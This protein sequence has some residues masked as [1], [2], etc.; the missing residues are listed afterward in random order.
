[1]E[2][3]NG[4]VLEYF[5]ESHTYIVDG[6]EV[7]SITQILKYKFGRKYEGVSKDIL[8]NAADAG[9]R[10]HNAIEDWCKN[11]TESDLPEVRNFKFLQKRYGFKVL[12]NEVPVI[13]EMDGKVVTAGRL[14]LVL[15]IDGKIGGGD[16]KRTYTLD[17]EYLAYQLNLY[18]IAYR[19]TYGV[20]WEFLKGVH[21]RNDTR[22][23]VDIPIREPQIW[24]FL[25]KWEA[26]NE[27]T[28]E[29]DTATV[30]PFKRKKVHSDAGTRQD[31]ENL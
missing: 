27:D 17:K 22:K 8:K 5:D 11:G 14:D 23:F 13:L 31:A 18:R 29:M 4:H 9:T 1:M 28:R 3:I 19:Q 30:S 24:E 12:E 10:V 15:E 16:I 25:R 26:Q 2:R 7:P 6:I 21:L 20:T